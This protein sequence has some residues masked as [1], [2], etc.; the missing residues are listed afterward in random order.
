MEKGAVPV[1]YIIA[2]ILGI[3]VVG[4][5]AYWF[6][7]LGG[8]VG[9]Q[10]S[11]TECRATENIYCTTW[12]ATGYGDESKPGGKDFSD[13]C[14]GTGT[15]APACCSYSWAQNVDQTECETALGII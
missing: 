10:A 2:L 7:V 3:V 9:D 13:T 15:Y 6:F 8:R 11:E 1:P 12:A 14:P 5:L 4:L